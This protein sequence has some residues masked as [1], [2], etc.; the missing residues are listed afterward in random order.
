MSPIDILGKSVLPA[1]PGK[2]V[3]QE[4]QPIETA[5]KDGTRIDVWVP[6]WLRTGNR[7]PNAKWRDGRWSFWWEPT[8]EW[9][10]IEEE[11]EGGPSH[12]MPLPPP[13][14]EMK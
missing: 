6:T 7:M 8:Q 4:W 11:Y 10:S 3:R 12:W 9:L 5:P 2:E 14:K 13:P 1:E